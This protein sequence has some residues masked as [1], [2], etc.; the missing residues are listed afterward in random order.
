MSRVLYCLLP[1]SVRSVAVAIK[2]TLS[3]HF[4]AAFTGHLVCIP[5]SMILPLPSSRFQHTLEVAQLPDTHNTTPDTANTSQEMARTKN[6]P[7]ISLR[8]LPGSVLCLL[9]ACPAALS[10]LHLVV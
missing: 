3:A 10:T 9:F 1:Y 5:W 8:R 2:V 7:M 4:Q 6:W